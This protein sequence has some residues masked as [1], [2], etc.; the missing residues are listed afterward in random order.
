M[1]R[2]SETA[3]AALRDEILSWDLAPGTVLA[4]V[5]LSGRLGISRTPVREA[6]A[7]LVADGLAA[8]QGGRGLV[9]TPVEAENVTELFELRQALESQAASLAALRRELPPFR[10]LQD[11]FREVP[12][13]LADPD[14]GR[15]S[16]YD[17]VARFDDAVDEAVQNPFLV[18]ALTAVRTHLARLRRLSRDNPAR[19]L[20]AAREHLLIVDAIVDGDA[21]LAADATRVHLYRSLQSTL[22]SL[23]RSL[24][25]NPSLIDSTAVREKDATP[26]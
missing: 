8:P 10:A 22:G 24:G 5:E 12:A 17:L 4:E 26:R 23:D 20:E 3:Y 21:R 25:G 7:R 14:P 16:Y 19:L 6:L 15:H 13:L 1:A 2:A 18:S 11:E 9:V